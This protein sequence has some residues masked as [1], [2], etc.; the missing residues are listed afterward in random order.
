LSATA[1]TCAEDIQVESKII[2]NTAC[3]RCH[4]GE[5]S[6]R[7]SF[8]LPKSA[9]DQHILHHGG[10]LPP[11][12]IGQ[13][14]E[15]LRYMKEEC[16]FYP[17]A[18]AY[19]QD[20]IWDSDELTQLRS[21][22]RQAYFVFLGDLEAGSYR[23]SVQGENDNPEYCIE[24]VNSEFDYYEKQQVSAKADKAVL[25]FS[26]DKSSG[27]YLRVTAGEPLVLHKLELQAIGKNGVTR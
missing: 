25:Q 12:R 18:S 5:C 7:M 26:A 14:F 23:L 10:E 13:L 11:E 2:F 24:V 6:G 4:E 27:Y 16:S 20:G 22:A 21:P 19:E 9:A 1:G 8:H 17:M 3:A 15:L